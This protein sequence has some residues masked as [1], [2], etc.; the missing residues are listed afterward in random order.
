MLSLLAGTGPTTACTVWAGS[1]AARE[2]IRCIHV[3]M[4]DS[5]G[6]GLPR[7][8][9]SS[10]GN[11]EFPLSVGYCDCARVGFACGACPAENVL[12]RLVC[13]SAGLVEPAEV[14]PDA[15]PAI[16]R[17]AANGP[18]SVAGSTSRW[19]AAGSAESLPLRLCGSKGRN[20]AYN[21]P[22][23]HVCVA[24]CCPTDFSLS[25]AGFCVAV[26]RW[27]NPNSSAWRARC[28]RGK[29]AESQRQRLCA[30]IF[31]WPLIS[32]VKQSLE[33]GKSGG[34]GRSALRPG[35]NSRAYSL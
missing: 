17:S 30:C 27:R 3:R 12:G 2:R 10:R 1:R 29:A 33:L 18:R 28:V 22:S 4:V 14:S 6:P 24:W 31:L 20:Q 15:A 25:P 23:C 8:L 16:P 34:G 5:R 35:G 19:A 13:R 9:G 26:A 11:F 21:P 7:T 32:G